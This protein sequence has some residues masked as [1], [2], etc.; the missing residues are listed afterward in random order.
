LNLPSLPIGDFG[1]LASSIRGRILSPSL[2]D[3][4]NKLTRPYLADGQ[5]RPACCQ[6][7]FLCHANGIGGVHGKT[8]RSAGHRSRSVRYPGS[9][10]VRA[11]ISQRFALKDAADAHRA[12]EGSKTVGSTILLP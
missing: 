10:K 5:Y 6:G 12:L 4:L 3:Q 11:E 2:V 1:S 9:G 8:Q 7:I